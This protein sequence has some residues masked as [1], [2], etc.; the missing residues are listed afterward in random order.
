MRK[1]HRLHLVVVLL[2][3]AQLLSLE[4]NAQK[5]TRTSLLAKS[6][7]DPSQHSSTAQSPDVHVDRSDLGMV[8]SDSAAASRVGSEVLRRGGN[9]VDA[10]IAT[11]FALA[12]TWPDA[13]NI[14]GG[15]FMMIRPSDGKDP[16]CIDYREVAPQTMQANSF[17]KTDTT[18][19]HK[20]VGV[21]EQ[22]GALSLP[23]NNMVR[24][25]GA[26]LSYPP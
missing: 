5:P 14:G 23:I 17:T 7:R 20:A 18:F 4:V 25:P 21:R 13:G 1:H 11:A 16:R 10:A 22:Y 3:L 12:V 6:E 26:N 8:V 9:A 15:G 19:A 2:W 24:C